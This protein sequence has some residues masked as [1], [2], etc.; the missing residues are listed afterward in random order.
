MIYIIRKP[1]LCWFWQHNFSRLK[2]DIFWEISILIDLIGKKPHFYFSDETEVN[3][4]IVLHVFND[5][6]TLSLLYLWEYVYISIFSQYRMSLY[7]IIMCYCLYCSCVHKKLKIFIFIF[8][9]VFLHFLKF[10]LCL[11]CSTR[12]YVFTHEKIIQFA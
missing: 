10:F 11:K 3:S 12:Q 6:L 8:Q 5:S 7:S 4:K 2:H 1:N 9:L